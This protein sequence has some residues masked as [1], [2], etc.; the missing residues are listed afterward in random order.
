[1]DPNTRALVMGA[2]GGAGSAANLYVEDVFNTYLYTGTGS[3]PQTL[4]TGV[5][6][7][8]NK[9]LVIYKARS[10]SFPL[11]TYTRA[12]VFSDLCWG[13]K[14]IRGTQDNAGNPYS[15]PF[16]FETFGTSGITLNYDYAQYNALNNTY[17]AYTFRNADKFFQ[18]YNGVVNV[19][20]NTTISFP[21]LGTIGMVVVQGTFGN[22]SPF[23]VWHRSLT[24]GKL[25]SL[26]TTQAEYTANNITVSGTDVTL[27]ASGYDG[28]SVMV[29]AFA[30]DAGGYGAS[31]ADSIVKC[32]SFTKTQSHPNDPPVVLGWEPQFLLFKRVDSG[33]EDWIIGDN[34]RGAGTNTG[35]GLSLNT[36]NLETSTLPFTPLATGFTI[37]NST[38]IG[39]TYIY[40]AIR[41]GPMKT[42]TDA[43]KVFSLASYT[44]N[45][46]NGRLIGSVTTDLAFFANPPGNNYSIK[47]FF[48][49]LRGADRYLT[50]TQTNGEGNVSGAQ[51]FLAFDQNNAIRLGSD[52]VAGY[53]NLSPYAYVSYNFRRAPG[54][55]DVVAYTG[56]GSARTVSHNL[57]V[58]PE[59]MI[60]KKRSATDAWVVYANN[61]NTDYLVLNTTAATVDNNTIWNDTS[62]TSSVFTVGTN[63]DVNGNTDTFIAYLFATCQGVSK[64]GSYTGTGT[65]LQINCGFT[66]GARFVLIK[67]TDS[68][69]D[70]YTWDTARGIISGND[71]YLLLNSSAAEVTNTDY[72]DPYSAGFEISSTAPAAINANGGNFIFLAIA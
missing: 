57:G 30:H 64:V 53:T 70:W 27:N 45:S 63:D 4:T 52:T 29:Y 38:S 21:Q 72:I 10:G 1:M 6:L 58:T 11:G 39:G 68:T 12:A 36:S 9:G 15:Q 3:T 62:P 50:S 24:A 55:F 34:M 20:S 35:A 60:V 41:R 16:D 46:T 44:G 8:D 18:A 67:R 5:N 33:S 56:T 28:G 26:N 65:T 71:P 13:T 37:G 23:Y 54:F 59:L 19:S 51:P 66:A 43:T 22:D 61:D 2:A 49:R 25:L 40:I 69:G 7:A 48:D 32:G 47:L 42:P 31:G 14:Y 17:V